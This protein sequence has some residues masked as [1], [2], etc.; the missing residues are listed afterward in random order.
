[1]L[2]R[3]LLLCVVVTA[4]LMP[5]ELRGDEP[6]RSAKET[7]TP[8]EIERLIRQLGNEEFSEREEA[9]RRLKK[10]GPPAV[11][12]LRA[13]IKSKDAE[14]SRRA[15]DIA[16]VIE[17]T[18]EQ[19]VIDYR[20]FGLPLPPK[21]AMLVRYE[22]G[23]GGLVNGKV[24][25]KVYAPAFLVK[26]GSETEGATLLWGSVERQLER[27]DGRPQEIDPTPEAVKRL[28]RDGVEL[29]FF[30][31]GRFGPELEFAIQC[32]DRGWHQLAHHL[33]DQSQQGHKLSPRLELIHSAWGYWKMQLARPKTDRAMIAKRLKELIDRDA[34]MDTVP[35]RALLK[36]LDLALVPSKAKPGSV[37]AMIDDLVDYAADTGSLGSYEREDRYSRIAELGFDA[38]PA[39]MEHLEDD[40]LTRAMMKGFN[41]FPS[42]HLRVKHV[43]SD[44]LQ[45]LAGQDLGRDWLRRQQGYTVEKAAAK[46]WW[47][48]ARMVGEEAYLLKHVL[49]APNAKEEN[50][51]TNGDQLHLI[52]VRY[53]KHVPELYRTVLYK[54]PELDSWSLADAVSRCKMP[55]QDK[56]DLLLY[57][58]KHEDNRHRL[59][60][61]YAIKSLDKKKF[62]AL[63]IAAIEGLP[64]DV[65]GPY[66]L[67]PEAEMAE[68]IS[69]SDDPRVWDAL[70]K[71]VKRSAVGFRMQLLDRSTGWGG[72]G[73]RSDRLRL[74]AAFL[75]DTAVRDT[76]SSKKYDGPCA[77]FVY[78]KLSVQNFVAMELAGLLKMEVELK[79]D[80]TS[81]EWAKIRRQVRDAVDRELGKRK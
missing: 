24:Q 41:N 31:L 10:I 6:A 17:N 32:Y 55:A 38:V 74:L 53:P 54:R 48:E 29:E 81:E 40:R 16:A 36:S 13:A 37:E 27:W 39:L 2:R 51:Q 68:L 35:N 33:L 71:V 26:S 30:R 20:A 23:G 9:S 5:V 67:S 49:P 47:D 7:P 3:W 78:R 60:A 4:W 59:A 56:L 75:D 19:L 64:N 57:A 11:P 42:W 77:G 46:M 14:V 15:T 43:V 8:A 25:P 62:N 65:P 76:E 28:G 52:V 22:A 18:L 44:L 70:T 66:W 63:V 34:E 21:D 72:I 12:A 50:R 61:L 69:D 45:G 80:R 58:A 1:M 73:H 79:P